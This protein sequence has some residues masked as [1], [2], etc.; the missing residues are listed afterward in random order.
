MVGYRDKQY[1]PFGWEDARL[2]DLL[3]FVPARLSILFLFLL[4]QHSI[5]NRQ[6]QHCHQISSRI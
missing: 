2:Y 5:R 6:F 1:S 4:E 3:S